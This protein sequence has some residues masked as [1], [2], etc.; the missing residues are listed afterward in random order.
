M[1]SS[2]PR[3]ERAGAAL[4]FAPEASVPC[5]AAA[6]VEPVPLWLAV[7]AEGAVEAWAARERLAARRK[8]EKEHKA[9]LGKSIVVYVSAA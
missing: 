1:P 6:C 8:A 4:F 2:T 7:E 9:F 3:K 5:A